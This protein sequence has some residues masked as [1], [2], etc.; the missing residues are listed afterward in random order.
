MNAA[1][2]GTLLRIF[3]TDSDRHEGKPLYEALVLRAREQRLAGATVLRGVI[4]YGKASRIHSARIEAISTGLPVVVEII[5]L[6]EKITAFL[7]Q[8]QAMA[9]DALVTLEQVTVL[10]PSSLE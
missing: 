5:D 2:N 10:R 6:E 7:P 1:R 3:T 8:V 4:G 9:P